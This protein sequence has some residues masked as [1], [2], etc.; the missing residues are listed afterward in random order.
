MEY[1]RF[2]LVLAALSAGNIMESH[3]G[4]ACGAAEH[5]Y[6]HVTQSGSAMD[7]IDD[8]YQRAIA[9]YDIDDTP[10]RDELK[11]NFFSP[12]ASSNAR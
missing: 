6:H 12:A 11:L 8:P 2:M 3:A 9:A 7:G 1:P 10:L 4:I 5:R